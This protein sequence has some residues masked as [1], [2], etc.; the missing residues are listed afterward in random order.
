MK[1]LVSCVITLALCVAACAAPKT[2]APP[3]A[4]EGASASPGV[5]DATAAPATWIVTTAA[6]PFAQG[7]L[8]SSGAESPAS[9]GAELVV[10]TAKALHAMQGFGGSFNEHGWDVLQLLPASA[11]D[12]VMRQIF[13]PTTGLGFN[14]C[15]TPIGASDYALDRYTLDE[16]PG[17]YA[18]TQFSIERDKKLLI[19]FIQAA[20]KIRPDLRLWA[21]AW[22]PPSWMKTNGAFDSGAM[23][24]DPKIYAAYALYLA[25]Y[26]EAYR[27]ESIDVS[28]VVPQNEPGQL[29]HYPSCDWTPTQYVS[30]IRDHLAPTLKT[31]G[32]DTQI[33]VGTVNKE[34]WDP[35]IVLKDPGA[36]AVISGVALQW[37]GLAHV[38]TLRSAY[39]DLTIM[40]SETE[41]GN[42]SRL[43]NYDPETP[44]NDFGYAA[45][46]FRKMR[47]FIGRGASSYMVWNMV[48]DEHGKNIDSLKQWPQ[49]S[50][51]V[52]DRS[53][54]QVTYTPM[55]WVTKHFSALIEPGARV[56]EISGAHPDRIAFQNPDGSV[57]VELMNDGESTLPL[58]VR[59]GGRRYA[60]EL[61]PKSFASLVIPKG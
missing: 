34:S 29:T 1:R 5:S 43:P 3:S 13:D 16:A 61:A 37:G 44:P 9:A 51:I 2:A 50:P 53:T 49:N 42:Q 35:L 26:V 28:M 52:V 15:R 25:K 57:V 17:D 27:G 10:D 6:S 40:Q 31:R 21:S 32:L 18:M 54:Q 19:P 36:A 30:F 48:L 41:C 12:A 39:P 20:L 60:V 59:S 55:F 23:K 56:V 58:H 22:T 45:Y 46:T 38:A 11:R 47:D 8:A 33:F 24:D 4:P 7:T 14:Y